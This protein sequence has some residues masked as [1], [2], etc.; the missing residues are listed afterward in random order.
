MAAPDLI[1]KAPSRGSLLT[2]PLV[3]TRKAS[4]N[5]KPGERNRDKPCAI[6]RSLTTCDTR[7]MFIARLKPRA[8]LLRLGRV[9]GQSLKIV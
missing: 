8:V 9:Y 1:A 3:T 4:R 5:G 2:A 7:Y 6:T